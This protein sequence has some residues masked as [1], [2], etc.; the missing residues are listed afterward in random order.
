MPEEEIREAE[1]VYNHKDKEHSL[2]VNS[3]LGKDKNSD[4]VGVFEGAGYSQFGLY[5]SM[6]D[7]I[8]FTKAQKN[9]CR[10][11]EQAIIGVIKFY[12]E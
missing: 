1:E 2:F 5:R 11:C 10:V 3:F 4:K 7:C 8:M 9:F 12:S 6:I